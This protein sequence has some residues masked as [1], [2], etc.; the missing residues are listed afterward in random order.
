[1]L[2]RFPCYSPALYSVTPIARHSCFTSAEQMFTL[3]QRMQP[4][5]VH[6]PVSIIISVPWFRLT[7]H[8]SPPAAYWVTDLP[9]GTT[10][11][12][13]EADYHASVGLG[14]DLGYEMMIPWPTDELNISGMSIVAYTARI[15][16]PTLTQRKTFKTWWSKPRSHANES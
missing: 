2:R 6:Q 13:E 3:N 12:R 11:S 10:K 16:Y 8:F 4:W 1:M 5:D 15:W 9:L 14:Y 7:L